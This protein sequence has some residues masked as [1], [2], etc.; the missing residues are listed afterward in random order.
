[1]QTKRNVTDPNSPTIEEVAQKAHAMLEEL[2]ELIP[3]LKAHD[4]G[5]IKRIAAAAKFAHELVTPA[6]SVHLASAG[7]ADHKLFDVDRG[8]DVLVLRDELIPVIQRGR[9]FFDALEFTM[10]SELAVVGEEALQLYAWLKKVAKTPEGAVLRPY[11]DEMA[12][13]IEKKLNR[14]PAKAAP[15]TTVPP[16]AH[17]FLPIAA[18]PAE[19]PDEASEELPEPYETFLANEART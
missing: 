9:A 10:N 13:S 2:E 8:R 11:V 15:T 1:M 17:T 14:R 7:V 3:D 4:A 5:A 16:G 18:P 19:E 12:R 6:I